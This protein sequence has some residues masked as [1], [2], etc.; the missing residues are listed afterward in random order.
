MEGVCAAMTGALTHRGPDD[1][2]YW[3]QRDVGLAMGHRRLS[4]V[5][6]SPAGHQPMVCASGRYWITFNGEIYNHDTLRADLER[7]GAAG[8]WRGHSDTETL[9][10]AIEAWGLRRTLERSVGM[11]ALALWDC[12]HRRLSLARDRAGE[13][14]LYYGKALRAFL[15]GSELKALQAHPNFAR[16]IDRGCLALYLRHN[17]VPEPR[18]IYRGIQRVPAGT[19]LE[20]DEFGRYG[21][22][23]PY[24]SLASSVETPPNGR[25]AGCD[26]DAVETLERVLGEAVG[27][28]MVAD[29]PLGAFLSGGID[30]SL[31]VALMQ[32]RSTRRVRTFTVGFSEPDYDESRYA[33]A[34]AQHLGTEHTE[35][36]VTPAEAMAVI[37]RLAAIYDEPFADSSQVPTHLVS[38]LARQHVT[39]SLSGDAGDELFGGYNRYAWAKRISDTMGVLGPLRGAAARAIRTLSPE[40]WSRLAGICSAF[41]PR[42]W[43]ESRA[44]DKLHKIADL[45]DC[46]PAEIYRALISH[47][48]APADVVVGGWEPESQLTEIMASSAT[49]RFEE[50]MMYWDFM[51]YLPGDILVKVDRAAMAVSLETRVPMLDH[52]VIEFAWSLPLRFRVRAGTGKWLLKELLSRYVPRTL[53]DRPKTGFG[54]PIDSWLRGPLRDW[55]ESLLDESRL[56]SEGFLNPAPIRQKWLEHVGG[57][58]NWAYWL[59]DVIMFQTW[60]EEQSRRPADG[61][62]HRRLAERSPIGSGTIPTRRYGNV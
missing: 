5:D 7:S 53:T 30:S 19:I 34:V 56:R 8:A 38:Q 31:V 42:R 58:R 16:E 33:R 20:V 9:L 47:W 54:I 10:A 55:A 2:G 3:F 40:T 48:P 35:L 14:P 62:D 29:V 52:R 11:F 32:R 43:R 25:F 44:G 37:P 28:Q 15:Y 46:S 22:P 41:V 50:N 59:W 39:V 4:I 61:G 36:I 12:K 18:S 24:W 51:T 17:Y 60:H 6:L 26:E 57:R 1:F 13:K 49:W 45:L 21:E 23:D 27:L